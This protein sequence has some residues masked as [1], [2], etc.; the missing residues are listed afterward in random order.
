MPYY[1]ALGNGDSWLGATIHEQASCPTLPEAGVR[2]L[3]EASVDARADEVDW[4]PTCDAREATFREVD[5]DDDAEPTGT[6]DVVKNDGEVC[7]RDR[8]CQYHD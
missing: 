2:P 4:C 3:G 6:C 8:P 7:G 5:A 1:A